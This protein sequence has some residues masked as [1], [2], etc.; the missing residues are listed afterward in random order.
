MG[1]REEAPRGAPRPPRP[2]SAPRP[3][4]EGLCPPPGPGRPF[5]RARFISCFQ[6]HQEAQG[7][8]LAVTVAQGTLIQNNRRPKA[9]FSGLLQRVLP[10]PPSL[11]SCCLRL[12]H[13]ACYP[14]SAYIAWVPM[15]GLRDSC[16]MTLSITSFH[17]EPLGWRVEGEDPRARA[18]CPLPSLHLMPPLCT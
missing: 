7:V 16:W 15:A 10:F 2:P 3:G 6:G 13:T 9:A 14:G 8:L 12:S 1:A 5:A 18:G 11:P 4:D 17:L